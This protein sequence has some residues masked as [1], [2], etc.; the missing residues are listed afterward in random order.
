MTA[1]LLALVSLLWI[2]ALVVW[3]WTESRKWRKGFRP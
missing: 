1:L 2:A 3:V